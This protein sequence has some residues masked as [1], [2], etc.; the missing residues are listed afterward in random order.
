MTSYGPD[1]LCHEALELGRK[2]TTS[3]NAYL[4]ELNE[5]K[6]QFKCKLEE[7][8]RTKEKF[9]GLLHV[10]GETFPSLNKEEK[11]C[12]DYETINKKRNQIF[13]RS[14]YENYKGN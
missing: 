4:I 5:L 12:Q 2:C 14:I 8:Y 9:E 1:A 6:N 13:T 11:S 3:F 7:I 10:I